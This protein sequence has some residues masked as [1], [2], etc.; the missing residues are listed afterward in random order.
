[1]S[2]NKKQENFKR[3]I[4]IKGM[5]GL[6]NPTFMQGR[7]YY[8]EKGLYVFTEEYLLNRGYCCSNNCRHCPYQSKTE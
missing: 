8:L 3:V 5:I 2:E 6:R 4:K 1:M 7:D